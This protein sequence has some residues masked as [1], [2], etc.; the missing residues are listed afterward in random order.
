MCGQR[1]QG[2]GPRLRRQVQRD[3]ME[4]EEV[5]KMEEARGLH[6]TLGKEVGPRCARLRRPAPAQRHDLA[7]ARGQLRD[8]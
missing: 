8:G 7:H 1:Q 5:C 6:V 4:E 3:M 2:R